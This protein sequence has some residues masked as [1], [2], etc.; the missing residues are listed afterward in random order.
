MLYQTTKYSYD[1]H[2]TIELSSR[3]AF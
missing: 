3:R 2:I 1:S